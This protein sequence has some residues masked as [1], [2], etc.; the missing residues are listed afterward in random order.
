MPTWGE[1]Q[2][3]ARGKYKLDEDG[4][5]FFS[6]VFGYDSGRSQ[7]IFVRRFTAFDKEWLEFRSVVCKESELAHRL[8]LKK[9]LQFAVGALAL[10]DDNDYVFLYSA[11]LDTMDPDE[12][13]L[14]LHVVAAMADKLESEHSAGDDDF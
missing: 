13:E 4:E 6:L 9:N 10:D 5:G 11:V 8:A 3:Y 1:I 12:F 2:E 7:K 14:P